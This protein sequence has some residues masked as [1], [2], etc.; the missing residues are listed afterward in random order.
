MDRKDIELAYGRMDGVV[1]KTP[2][3]RSETFSGMSGG[4]VHLKCENLQKTGSF[5]AR[6]AYNMMLGLKSSGWAGNA[7]VACSAGNHAQGVAYAAKKLGYAATI[8]MPMTAPIAKISATAGYGAK[9]ELCGDCYDDTYEMASRLAEKDGTALIPAFDNADII[10]GQG[11]VGLEILGELPEAEVVLVPCG[12]GG[13]LAGVASY[14]KQ[15]KPDVKIVGVQAEGA[16]AVVSAF[17]KKE[18]AST[19]SVSTI[20][21]GIAVKMPGKLTVGLILRYVDE[22]VSVSDSEISDAILLLL[23]RCKQVVEPAGAA[24]VAAVLAG[25]VDIRG[26]KAVCVLSGGNIDVDFIQRIVE[27]GLVQRGRRLQFTTTLPDRPGSLYRLCG[28]ISENGGNILSLQHDRLNNKLGL[29]QTVV[30][31][32]LE[33]GG[34]E[35]G[36]ALIEAMNRAGYSAIID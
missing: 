11:T 25:K 31:A 5:K 3:E 20:A 17:G 8:V 16:D 28:I 14:I 34:T 29:N 13:L 15:V 1:H 26:K 30:H 36:R 22:M 27:R 10:A 7:V 18:W 35:H 33:V 19:E 32:A 2:L 6:G 23:E 21:D 24:A 12:G 4:E 9:V